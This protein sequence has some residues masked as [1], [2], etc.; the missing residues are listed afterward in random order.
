M[1]TYYGDVSS[2]VGSQSSFWA[3]FIGILVIVII[4]ATIIEIIKVIAE[5]KIFKKAGKEGGKALIPFYNTWVLCDVVGV[6][7]YWVLIT[8]G[9]GFLSGM[10]SNNEY[11]SGIVGLLVS[12]ISIYFSVILN[13]SLARSFGKS[14]GFGIASIFFCPICMMILAF[15]KA[16]YL[17]PKPMNDV[18]LNAFNQ[19]KDE[20]PKATEADVKVEDT[21]KEDK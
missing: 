6:N 19:K 10:V 12:A 21:K 7:P 18:I 13:I 5:W 9:S 15:S 1:D 3:I 14:D 16:E 20:A 17:G 4:F 8:I 11:L 2:T